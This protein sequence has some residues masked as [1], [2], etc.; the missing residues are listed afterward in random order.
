MMLHAY[1]YEKEIKI[2]NINFKLSAQIYFKYTCFVFFLKKIS[3]EYF[4][5]LFSADSLSFPY[6]VHYASMS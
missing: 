2:S 4:T 5:D 3:I 6:F 1:A